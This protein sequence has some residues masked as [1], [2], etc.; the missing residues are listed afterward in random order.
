MV[1]LSVKI[2][3]LLFIM[4]YNIQGCDHYEVHIHNNLPK[5]SPQLK[6]HCASGDDDLGYKYPGLGTDFNWSFCPNPS[7]L[8]F[9][10]FWWAGKDLRF[11][12]FNN[13]RVCVRDGDR[14]VPAVTTKC[15][16]QVQAD[17]FYLGYFDDISGQ[18]KFKKYRDW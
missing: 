1:H 5:N 2:L 10:H 4:P 14:F 18:L 11:D 6:L 3:F 9:C 12:V 13:S 7:T 15:Q 16:W 17:G 8:F